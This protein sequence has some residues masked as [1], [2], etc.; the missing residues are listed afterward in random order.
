MNAL[1]LPAPSSLF[2]TIQAATSNV[3]TMLAALKTPG[4]GATIAELIGATTAL[5][6]LSVVGALSASFYA[7]A[8][9][10][11]LIVASNTAMKC[12][13][14]ATVASTLQTWV[15]RNR[16]VIPHSILVF[17]QRHPEVLID[18]PSRRNYAFL[19]SHQRVTA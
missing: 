8:C 10:G 13:S 9:I 7:G 4:P 1:G 15:G 16:R 12:T 19:A 5:E 2:G 11:S 6:L 14:R 3:A 18:T 17:I